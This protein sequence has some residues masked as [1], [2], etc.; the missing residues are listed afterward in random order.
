[1]RPSKPNRTVS[2]TTK[3][4]TKQLREKWVIGKR[5]NRLN[6]V[7]FYDS[8]CVCV[9]VN[10]MQFQELREYANHYECLVEECIATV[11]DIH[12]GFIVATTTTTTTATAKHA[13]HPSLEMI[14]QPP[15]FCKRLDVL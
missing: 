11:L 8:V 2:E 4:F 10:L 13:Q 15:R 7:I 14:A 5:R 12:S 1:M 6:I 9:C 3:L